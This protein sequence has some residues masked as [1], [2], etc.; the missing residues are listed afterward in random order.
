MTLIAAGGVISGGWPYIT[1]AYAITWLFLAGY[2]VY[3]LDRSG[4]LKGREMAV[5]A[6]LVVLGLAATAATFAIS[7]L[8]RGMVFTGLITVGLVAIL[9]GIT[10]KS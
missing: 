6:A 1:A 9:R 4:S 2:A 10:R 8:E 7:G 5:G 3:V